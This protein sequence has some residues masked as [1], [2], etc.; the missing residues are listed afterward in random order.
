MICDYNLHCFKCNNLSEKESR[1][2]KFNRLDDL[3]TT[4]KHIQFFK[5]R[6]ENHLSIYA[7]LTR[8]NVRV[9]KREIDALMDALYLKVKF[10]HDKVF[11]Q[12]IKSYV[13]KSWRY[14]HTTSSCT[15]TT[16]L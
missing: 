15:F 9:M 10:Q 12:T 4:G 7:T 5:T 8:T 11:L 16:F 6:M 1:Y 13:K 14:I 3:T 2:I